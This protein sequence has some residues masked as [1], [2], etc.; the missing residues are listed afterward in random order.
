[1]MDFIVT[2]GGQP[3]GEVQVPGDKSISHRAVL[4]G[5]IARGDTRIS[6]LLEGEDVLR[7]VEA[8]RAMGVE[9]HR[10]GPG[11]LQIRGVGRSGLQAPASGDLDLGNSGTAMRLL[12]GLLAGQRFDSTLRGDA[13][14]S[15]RPMGRVCTPLGEMGAEISA[16][17]DGCP[18]LRIRGGQ[19]LRGIRHHAVVAS[20][21]VKSALLL[22][23][24]YASGRTCVREPA[25]SRDH[26]ER[27]LQGFGV[28][29]E[30]VDGATCLRGGQEL[31]GTRL[32]VPGDISSAAFFL[33]GAAISPGAR[34]RLPGV[35]VNPTR[36]GILHLLERMGARIER[37]NPR[38]AGGEPVADLLVEGG[39]LQ[40]IHVAPEEVPG[41]ID[42]FPALLVAAA[43]ARGET[44][45]RGARELRV[46]ESDR[47][48]VMAEGL[49][50]AGI[51]VEEQEDGILVRGGSFSGAEIDSHG[52]HRIA[53]A[54]AVAGWRAAGAIRVRDTANVATSFPGFVATARGAGLGIQE[55]TA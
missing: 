15:R 39:E 4:L 6:G 2:P 27:M 35:G 14:L 45:V 34:L 12:A 43:F 17:E 46:K 54:F 1:M 16:T 44:R 22:A 25:A 49:R 21:Q 31:R 11:L 41:S 5:A 29:V 32:E 51:F 13:S 33:V 18:P 8:F 55:H 9:I 42:E 36:T 19:T 37:S 10:E 23:G 30:S 38:L 47:L 26:T 24:L 20:A 7:T 48:A 40:G 50:R 52:D 3:A 53:M 28:R